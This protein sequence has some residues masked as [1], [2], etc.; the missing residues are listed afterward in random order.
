MEAPNSDGCYAA[1]LAGG[2]GTRF[3]PASRR[4]KPKPFI[5]LLGS[6]PL[7]R[8][9]ARRLVPVVG[10]EGL[11]Y[12]VGNQLAD[13]TRNVVPQGNQALIVE[14]P[15]AR[16]TLG[17]VLL[18]MGYAWS[19]HPN[20]RLAVFPSDH[21]IPDVEAFQRTLRC[22]Y[23]LAKH[24]VV[25]MGILPTRPETGFGYIRAGAEFRDFRPP[26]GCEDLPLPRVVEQFVEKP[27]IRRA[28]QFLKSGDYL[29]N[30]GIFVISVPHFFQH[31]R[32]V[33]PYYAHVIS[34][35]REIYQGDDSPQRSQIIQSLLDPLPNRNIDK[36]AMETCRDML[37][38]PAAFPW[39]DVGSWDALF[40]GL[41]PEENLLIGNTVA[42]ESTGNVV[43]STSGAPMVAC[44]GVDDL[45]VVATPDAV[46]VTRRGKGQTVGELVKELERRGKNRV[47]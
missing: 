45:V 36:A 9:T 8:L 19:K 4:N 17:A 35:A 32:E 11:F 41:G 27:N 3:W 6:D 47:L 39:S 37:V 30:A 33:D 26:A 46:M 2:A 18:A 29:W 31:L 10:K 1:I 12:V 21:L 42:W 40:E 20:P 25:S 38:L 16:N 23:L 44:A 5:S 22:G 34:R 28:R 13:L 24:N 7:I 15:I 43:I 14:E